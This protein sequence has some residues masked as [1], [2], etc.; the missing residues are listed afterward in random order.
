MGAESPVLTPRACQDAVCER[1]ARITT[2]LASPVRV[3]EGDVVLLD[4]RP[5]TRYRAGHLPGVRSIPEC[6]VA[7]RAA[8][9]PVPGGHGRG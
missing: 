3:A 4:L 8:G 7:D 9:R 5:G 6:E 1:F 2:A